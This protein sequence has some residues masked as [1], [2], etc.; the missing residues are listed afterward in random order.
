MIDVSGDGPDN[1]GG[2]LDMARKNALASGI[3][4]NGLSIEA[5][6]RRLHAYT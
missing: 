4:I 6:E 2:D 3:T 1:S 5:E